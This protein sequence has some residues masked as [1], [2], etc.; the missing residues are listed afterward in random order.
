MTVRCDAGYRWIGVET[1]SM[2][3]GT[4]GQWN[5][6]P[7]CS[8]VL[9]IFIKIRIGKNMNFKLIKQHLFSLFVLKNMDFQMVINLEFMIEF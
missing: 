2:K 9:L 4:N 1:Q 8:R 3:C 6:Y 7:A 5:F